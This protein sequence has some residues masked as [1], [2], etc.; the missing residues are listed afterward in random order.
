MRL[1]RII[2]VKFHSFPILFVVK[3]NWSEHYSMN[4][5]MLCTFVTLELRMCSK[6]A[7]ILKM[8]LK[9]LKKNSSKGHERRGCYDLGYD[10]Y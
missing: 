6:I 9:G 2:L 5:S 3:K 1:I 10:S 7:D 4:E 8:K